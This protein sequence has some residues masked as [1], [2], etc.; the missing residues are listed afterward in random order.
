MHKAKSCPVLTGKLKDK[1][2]SWSKS[3]AKGKWKNGKRVNKVKEL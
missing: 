2:I 3:I 1:W